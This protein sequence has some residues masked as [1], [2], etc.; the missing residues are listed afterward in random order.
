[1]FYFSKQHNASIFDIIFVL[2]SEWWSL[3]DKL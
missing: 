3:W 1:M 2:F